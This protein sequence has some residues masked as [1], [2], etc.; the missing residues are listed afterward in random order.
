MTLNPQVSLKKHSIKTC[1]LQK[2]AKKK[3]QNVH[4]V[5]CD[6]ACHVTG[7][8]NIMYNIVWLV[9]QIKYTL[10]FEK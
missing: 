9:N 6:L 3:S 5:Y 1:L 2:I 7:P 4:N 10:L 8:Y